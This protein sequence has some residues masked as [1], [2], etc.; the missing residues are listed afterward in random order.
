MYYHFSEALPNNY[1]SHSHKLVT[2]Y[3][4]YKQWLA[5][6]RPRQIDTTCRLVLLNQRMLR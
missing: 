2:T 4:P 6:H 3:Y 1:D 5:I